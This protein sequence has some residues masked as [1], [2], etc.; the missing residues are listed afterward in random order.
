MAIRYTAEE[1]WLP[2]RVVH[3]RL[4]D[5]FGAETLVSNMGS[6]RL[7]RVIEEG[8]PYMVLE[9]TVPHNIFARYSLDEQF[10]LVLTYKQESTRGEE[11][12]ERLTDRE[13]TLKRVQAV[14]GGPSRHP[15]YPGQGQ[16][17]GVSLIPG[18][19]DDGL[20]GHAGM[21][22]DLSAVRLAEDGAGWASHLFRILL[23][24]FI[25]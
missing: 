25:L 23:R 14:P 21:Q 16:R 24:H 4:D 10:R 3:A 18:V 22:G 13:I 15:L 8:V 7:P 2:P 1:D 17:G 6:A 11:E 9:W 5:V 19:N 20:S 12:E